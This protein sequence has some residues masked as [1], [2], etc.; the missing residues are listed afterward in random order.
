MIPFYSDMPI[1]VITFSVPMSEGAPQRIGFA[2]TFCIIIS[3]TFIDRAF[4]NNN[5]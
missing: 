4:N 2:V 3:F 5:T 1:F